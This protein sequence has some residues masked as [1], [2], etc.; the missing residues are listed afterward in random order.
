MSHEYI[1]YLSTEERAATLK[2]AMAAELSR[3]GGM[4]KSARAG[5]AVAAGLAGL[6]GVGVGALKTVAA[7]SLLVGV[8][9]GVAAHALDR[10]TKITRNKERDKL[11]NIARYRSAAKGL[12]RRLAPTLM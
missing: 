3:H 12:E 4:S 7:L 6:P 11:N 5:A 10:S 9:L 8:P 2:V 1:K